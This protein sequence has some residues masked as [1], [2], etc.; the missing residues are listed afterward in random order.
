MSSPASAETQIL[1]LLRGDPPV[2]PGTT[3]RE[4]HD[5]P[6]RLTQ[7]CRDRENVQMA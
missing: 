5:A 2:I 6:R 1:A 3:P 4:H 7:K